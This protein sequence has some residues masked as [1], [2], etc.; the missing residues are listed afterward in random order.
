MEHHQL[1]AVMP[2]NCHYPRL[3]I[4]RKPA[5]PISLDPFLVE[6]PSG[7]YALDLQPMDEIWLTFCRDKEGEPVYT[8]HFE[9]PIKPFAERLDVVTGDYGPHFTKE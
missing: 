7:S 5:H 3:A 9:R 4:V 8:L 1:L 2:D 6:L